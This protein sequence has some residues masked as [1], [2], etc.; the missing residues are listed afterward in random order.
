MKITIAF[1]TAWEEPHLE[2]LCAGIEQQ[3]RSDDKIEL[4]VVDALGRPATAL[5]AQ[6]ILGRLEHGQSQHAAAKQT[7]VSVA[8]VC[9][10]WNGNVWPELDRPWIV[11]AAT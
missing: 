8:T 2:W 7:G 1:I 3:A 10:L 5:L 4:I 9:R 11:G 6:E